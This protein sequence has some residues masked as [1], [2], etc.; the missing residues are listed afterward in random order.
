MKKLMIYIHGKGGNA[1][2][3]SHYAELFPE[4]AVIGL[5]Y[6]SNTPWD[7][8][9]EFPGLI[10]SIMEAGEYDSGITVIANSI[11]AFFFM[12]AMP[13]LIESGINVGMAYFISPVVDMESLIG[14]LMSLAGVTEEEL[15]EKGT[16]DTVFGETLSYEYLTYVRENPLKYDVP[17]EI[18]YGEHDNLTT[19]GT[20]AEFAVSHCAG[21]TIMENGEHWFHTPEEME[22]LDRWIVSV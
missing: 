13:A 2:E 12:N 6:R 8:A 21:L 11:G 3:A 15:A 1:D 9:V 4:R 14:G 16:I 18:L 5:E 22:F 10:R 7:A 19:G 20:I 17:T